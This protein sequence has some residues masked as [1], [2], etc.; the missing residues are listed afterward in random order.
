MTVPS[1]TSEF[2]ER[3]V[4]L[5]IRTSRKEFV[6]VREHCAT[7]VFRFCYPLIRC[8]VAWL[9]LRECRTLHRCLQYVVEECGA[10][11]PR[12]RVCHRTRTQ[13]QRDEQDR[14]Q[15]AKAENTHRAVSNTWLI[16]P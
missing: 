13:G 15:T 3:V 4:Q 10:I 14:D 2:D 11:I 9:K 16:V 6:A 12:A 8:D 1:G 5:R 7:D